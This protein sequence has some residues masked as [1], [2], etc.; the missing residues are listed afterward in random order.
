MSL[1]LDRAREELVS[2]A[3][4][5]H[6]DPSELDTVPEPIRRYFDAS[7]APGAAVLTAVTLRMRGHIKVRRWLPFRADEV[8]APRRGFV[9]RARAA[10][11][12]GGYDAY[13][14]GQ[15]AMQWKLLGVA[16]LMRAD[17]SDVTTS[18][19]GRCG[20]EGMWLPTALLPRFDVEWSA[21]EADRIVAR[22]DVD[23][24]PIELHIRIDSSGR[25]TSVA[26]DRWGDPD[27]TGSFGWHRFG[28][29]IARHMTFNGLTIPSAGSW[30][31]FYGTDR[32]QRGEFFR[33]QIT[34][35]E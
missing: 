2:A 18:A 23:S 33:C 17:G 5:G 25:P 29:D 14:D 1:D 9:W 8:L 35:L 27:E 7:I 22:F 10:G 12:I 26:F 3:P 4:L 20:G 32:W 34:D 15:G 6:F 28:G 13:L 31:W 24:T 19:A 30:G 16:T 11:L 21:P